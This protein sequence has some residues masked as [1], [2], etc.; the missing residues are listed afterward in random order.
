MHMTVN[1]LGKLLA[2]TLVL[3]LLVGPAPASARTVYRC[4]QRGTVSLA[5]APE[6][7]SKCTA[8]TIDDNAAKLPNLWGMNGTQK[9]TLYE[10]VQDGVTV[11]STR[12]LPGSTPVL[13]FAVTPPPGSFAHAGLGQVGKPQ[14]DQHSALF[15]AAAKA[16][17][18]ED[19]WL[20][21]IAHAESGF[22]TN[23]VSPKGAQGV[24]QLMP[25]TAKQ[26]RVK[27]PFS[28]ADSIGGGARLLAD[29][30]RRY[31]GNHQLAAAAY[32]A[33]VGAVSKY[34][35]VPP[36]AETQAYVAKVDKLF[37]L[38]QAALT[39]PTATASTSVRLQP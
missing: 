34:G 24:M 10:R 20:R 11:Y 36:Y 32:N 33:G 4:M 26:Y 13:Q 27:D 22:R 23:A 3:G 12:N 30:L 5:T 31:K 6:P 8:Q 35:G 39:R 2:T 29:L 1:S 14:T 17:R 9:G 7:G 19:A 25:T 37:Q 15:T 21:A 28:A 18:V 38:Y 16:N